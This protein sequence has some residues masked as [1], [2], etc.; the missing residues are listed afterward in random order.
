MDL[1]FYS[2]LSDGCAQNVDSEF[3][4]SQAYGGY[5]QGNK[6]THRHRCFYERSLRLTV[7]NRQFTANYLWGFFLACLFFKFSEGSDSYLTISGA[8]HPFLSSEVSGLH[9]T[10]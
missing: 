10:A 5:S 7:S 2:E 8:G 1:N 3:L 9:E 4:D 6:V